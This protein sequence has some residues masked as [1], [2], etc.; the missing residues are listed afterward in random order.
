MFHLVHRL[1]AQVVDQ[2]VDKLFGA[3]ALDAQFFVMFFD[4][5]ANG[6]E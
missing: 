5:M 2:L 1:V 4:V 6:M 3:D